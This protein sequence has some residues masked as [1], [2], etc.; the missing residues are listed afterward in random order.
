M[1]R[2]VAVRTNHTAGEVRD[3]ARRATDVAQARRLWPEQP[4]ARAPPGNE[5]REPT[6]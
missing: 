2:A 6:R 1:G 3:F 5:V 4:R